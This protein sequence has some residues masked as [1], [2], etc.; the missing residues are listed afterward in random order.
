MKIKIKKSVWMMLW[1]MM[2]TC[3]YMTVSAAADETAA[4][5]AD[6][7]GVEETVNESGEDGL[8]ASGLYEVGRQWADEHQELFQTIVLVLGL[9]VYG[10]VQLIG[11]FRVRKPV[12]LSSNNAVEM[13]RN[14]AQEIKD[15]KKDAVNRIREAYRLTEETVQQM[16]EKMES[17]VKVAVQAVAQAQ[18]KTE[19]QTQ[20]LV[21]S[22]EAVLLMSRVV[23]RLLEESSLPART[24]D[25]IHA[26]VQEAEAKMKEENHG[27]D[28][29]E[30]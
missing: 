30:L 25:E 9:V 8:T 18:V 14:T 20:E 29:A 2:L 19:E 27:T 1:A 7:V 23:G 13:Y 12:V 5:D 22:R 21:R 6:T 15:V 4:E 3:L 10:G 28:A 16:Q 26:L 11:Y 24:R 17:S